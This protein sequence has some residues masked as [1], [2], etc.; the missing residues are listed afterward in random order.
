MLSSRVWKVWKAATVLALVLM[1]LAGSASALA[2]TRKK[3]PPRRVHHVLRN[4]NSVTRRSNGHVSDVHDKARGI[5]IHHGVNGG[6]SVLVNRGDS[7]IMAERGRPG[8]VE[9]RYGYRGHDYYRRTY[10]Y[11]GR[12]YDH[13]YRGYLFR[14]VSL[15]VYAPVHYY[16]I[17]FYGWAY[18]PWRTQVVYAWGWGPSPWYGYYGS[19][20]RPYSVY[21]GPAAWLTDYMIS[22]DLQAAYEAG[23]EAGT[24]GPQQA[25]GTELGM[26]QE[27]KDQVAAE[28]QYEVLLENAEAEKIAAQQ[29]VDPGS[30]GIARIL[31]DGKPHAFVVG[32]GLDVDDEESGEDCSFT[33]GDVLGLS[34]PAETDDADKTASLV[35]LASKGPKE[36]AKSAIVSVHFDDLQEM[37]NHM[38]E[39]IDQG[40]D[41][42]QKK[43]GTAGLPPAPPAAAGPATEAPFAELAP[44]P[45]PNEATQI[46]ALEKEAEQSEKEVTAQEK[47]EVK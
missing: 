8:F 42:L 11:H 16:S 46:A 21:S 39:M 2:P 3:R 22:N 14:G 32:R 5:D 19:Y 44:P 27:T 12:A 17:G 34:A 7:R 29:D 33:E 25:A 24:L 40:M 18:H 20:F 38:R 26:S 6:R 10:Y 43:Q 37:Q 45:D 23:R 9:H 13:F 41:E 4:G 30:S 35:V 15:H 28:V 31:A 1:C 36:C 47:Q